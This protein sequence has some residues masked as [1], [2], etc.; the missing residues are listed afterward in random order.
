ML[1]GVV[2]GSRAKSR[3]DDALSIV[4]LTVYSLPV[5][6]LGMMFVLVFGNLARQAW[7]TVGNNMHY[8]LYYC[9]LIAAIR[10]NCLA[11]DTRKT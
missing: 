9:L 4:T 5:F 11:L 2:Q 1:L 8:V 7:G 3:T 6:W 10:Y